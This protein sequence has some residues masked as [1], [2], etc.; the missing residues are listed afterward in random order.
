M[1]DDVVG[2]GR[3]AAAQG[4]EFGDACVPDLDDGEFRRHKER[5]SG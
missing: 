5:R 2:N 1:I 4:L 3:L